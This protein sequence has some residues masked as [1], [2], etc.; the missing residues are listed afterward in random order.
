MPSPYF[1]QPNAQAYRYA[2]TGNEILRPGALSASTMRLGSSTGP[3][4]QPGA[5]NSGFTLPTPVGVGG[6]SSDR[7]SM[8]KQ[9]INPELQTPFAK[10][11]GKLGQNETA[12]ALDLGK[13]TENLLSQ[14]TKNLANLA[15]EQSS[16]DD[17]YSGKIAG[18]LSGIRNRYGAAARQLTDQ[19]VA[20]GDRARKLN[21]IGSGFGGSSYYNRDVVGARMGANAA[22]AADLA[23]RERA[24]LGYDQGL[25][26]ANLGRR[27]ELGLGVA[28][29]ALLPLQAR[30]AVT[31]SELGNLGG[32]SG[33]YQGNQY[34]AV[35][36]NQQPYFPQYAPQSGYQP[37]NFNYGTQPLHAG[38]PTGPVLAP[39]GSGLGGGLQSLPNRSPRPSE[40][41][42]TG[43]DWE[44]APAPVSPAEAE[45][46]RLRSFYASPPQGDLG[47]F[48]SQF[49]NQNYDW[50]NGSYVP[51]VD[52]GAYERMTAPSDPY[53]D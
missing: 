38:R 17:I 49:S 48:N 33:L 40:P 12:N 28:S 25:R 18:D 9:I 1:S 47:D 45:R 14:S 43:A 10:Q 13:Y 31:R 36:D 21:A 51:H 44:Q 53:T 4:Y 41:F 46:A 8:F 29:D 42:W 23:N 27:R 32:L 6:G 37:S 20:A 22:L 30:D 19:A 2:D 3:A 34:T 35:L 16:I 24:D 5:P 11:L 15:S 7:Y 39:G 26:Q 50:Q 52:Q